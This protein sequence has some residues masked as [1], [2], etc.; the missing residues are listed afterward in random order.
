MK[1]SVRDVR[2]RVIRKAAKTVQIASALKERSVGGGDI[3]RFSPS[4]ARLLKKK[5]YVDGMKKA[6]HSPEPAAVS[7]N[8][9]SENWIRPF[10]WY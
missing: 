7:C 4:F 9:S 10:L 8:S 3:T 6:Q 1:G 5:R 2:A